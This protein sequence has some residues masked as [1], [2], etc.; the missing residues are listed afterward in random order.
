MGFKCTFSSL[1][2][3]GFTHTLVIGSS[4]TVVWYLGIRYLVVSLTALPDNF[5]GNVY[6]GNR[7][8]KVI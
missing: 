7:K 8:Y 1:T 2:S 3:L 6:D 5:Q 4:N